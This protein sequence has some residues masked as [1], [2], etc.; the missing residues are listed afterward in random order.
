M[1]EIY[2]I[3]YKHTSRLYI[4]FLINIPLISLETNIT[5]ST[6]NSV[7]PYSE[8]EIIYFYSLNT[9]PATAGLKKEQDGEVAL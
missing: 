2:Y 8:T 6:W 1:K 7:Q 3:K 5:S 4:Q 9:S